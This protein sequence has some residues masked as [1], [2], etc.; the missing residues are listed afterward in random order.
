[1]I[2]VKEQ[3]KL[4]RKDGDLG[5]EIELEGEGFERFG[6]MPG[7]DWRVEHDGSLRG[8]AVELVLRDPLAFEDMQRAVALVQDFVKRNRMTVY[9]TGR[10]GVHIHVN[11]QQCS[12]AQVYNMIMLYCIFEDQLTELCGEY[13]DGNLFCLRFK[14]AEALIDILRHAAVQSDKD[15]FRT[16]DIRYAALNINSLPRYGSLEFRAMRSTVDTEKLSVWAGIL[17][18][19]R[20]VAKRFDNP[21][22]IIMAFSAESP[23]KLYDMVFEQFPNIVP[24]DED[25][26]RNGMRR[27]QHIAFSTDDW[28]FDQWNLFSEQAEHYLWKTELKDW[29]YREELQKLSEDRDLYSKNRKRAFALVDEAASEVYRIH[30]EAVLKNRK[31]DRD[32]ERKQAEV[33]QAMAMVERQMRILG[34]AGGNAFVGRA[35]D[36]AILQAGNEVDEDYDELE[37]DED[38]W[39]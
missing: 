29:M 25:S 14:D 18:N 33:A 26:M 3:Y 5:V 15:L 8:D 4:R 20:E 11:V 32:D 27:A 34:D 37:D 1:V 2:T 30:R 21:Q 24:F 35:I 10:A 6:L 36:E 9:D 7:A 19:I 23:R 12:M 28:E 16:D 17:L 39:E 38:E 13:R 22:E 31:K